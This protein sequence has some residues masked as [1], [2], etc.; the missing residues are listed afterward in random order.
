ML[1]ITSRLNPQTYTNHKHFQNISFLGRHPRMVQPD[2]VIADSFVKSEKIKKRDISVLNKQLVLF[3]L[4]VAYKKNMLINMGE[5]P[6][7]VYRLASVAGPQEFENFLSQHN[8]D[9]DFYK[10]G[11]RPAARIADI[12]SHDM[13]NVQSGKY[14]ANLHIHSVHSDGH[15]TISEILDQAVEYADKRVEKNGAKEPFYVAITDHNTLEGSKEALDLIYK[16]PQKYKN[17]K[18]VLG[19]EISAKTPEIKGFQ[20][21]K[22]R[23]T[24]I[25]AMCVD[26]HEEVFGNYIKSLS[27]TS[28]TVMHARYTTLEEIVEN[29]QGNKNVK[30]GLAHPA[31][32]N[33]KDDLKSSSRYKAAVLEMIQQFQRVTKDKGLFVEGYYQGYK[34]EL[35]L[36]KKLLKL[37]KRYCDYLGLLKD[38]GMDTHFTSIFH[39]CSKWH[40]KK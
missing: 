8:A 30:L 39:S 10:P 5:N 37:I 11:N 35:S 27:E 9:E 23:T 17:I 18:V 12:D 16:N 4:D 40:L 19:V 36:D 28:H 2:L 1:N 15:L 32:P 22:P 24:H 34:D 6:K 33:M 14:G 20:F 13:S 7:N 3:P 26:P 29:L 21:K 38:G 31:Y 25:L